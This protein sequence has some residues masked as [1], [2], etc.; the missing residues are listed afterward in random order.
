MIKNYREPN[1]YSTVKRRQPRVPATVVDMYPLVIG[2]G[3][4]EYEQLNLT[5]ESVTGTSIALTDVTPDDNITGVTVK[6]SGAEIPA[7]VALV[8]TD[9]KV[10]TV[11]L[12]S[13]VDGA[14]LDVTVDVGNPEQYKLQRFTGSDAIEEFYGPK[15]ADGK[16]NNISLGAQIAK[17]AGSSVVYVLQVPT[18][19]NGKLLDAYK[20]AVEDN[21]VE[22]PGNPVWRMQPV[23]NDKDVQDYIMKFV[24]DMSTPEERS[25][26]YYALNNKDAEAKVKVTDVTES[27]KTA[28]TKALADPTEYAA[29]RYQTFYPNVAVCTVE[30]DGEE[31]DIEVGGEFI[32]AA[33]AGAEQALERESQSLTCSTIPAFIFKSLKG[34]KMKRTEKNALAALGVTLL[35][36]DEENGAITVRDSLSMDVS[37]EQNA[38]PCV[39]R[40]IDYGSKY[41]R[42]QLHP[43]LGKYNITPETLSK[44]QAAAASA[45]HTLVA[46]KL[47]VTAEIIDIYQNEDDLTNVIINARFGVAYPLKTIDVNIV[48]D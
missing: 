30:I 38:D 13:E 42:A 11:T 6:N 43:Y 20:K 37:T 14:T 26:K 28:V 47:F 39:T 10:W 33:I 45:M 41:V 25:E 21:V 22:I 23:D 9:A 48:C 31:K 8:G 3:L 18:P 29:Y 44:I 17:D 12:A 24:Y 15:Y 1:V 16:I 7:S 4:Y 35:T 40:A 32:G 2:T 5:Y 27:F 19:A 36:Q 34:V 46:K